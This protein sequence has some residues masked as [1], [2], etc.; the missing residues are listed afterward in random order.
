[1]SPL[2]DS[3]P[4]FGPGQVVCLEYGGL[5]LYAEA[6]QVV[7]ARQVCWVRPLML[8]TSVSEGNQVSQWQSQEAAQRFLWDLRDGA[9]L[10]WP[11][12]L[13]RAALD[14]EVIPLLTQLHSLGSEG[15]DATAAHQ[16]LRH[17]VGQVWQAYPSAFQQSKL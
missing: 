6:I 16:E 10:L 14:T 3:G 5:C 4:D 2:V 7:A 1:M 8:V 13:F 15:K 12:S 9:D 17:F 11:V